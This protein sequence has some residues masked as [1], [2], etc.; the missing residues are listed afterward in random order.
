MPLAC[1]DMISVRR[2][3][4]PRGQPRGDQ[5]ERDGRGVGQHVRGV[6]D[7]R[8]RVRGQAGHDL[9]GHERQDQGERT[10]EPPG[11]RPGNAGRRAVAMPVSSRHHLT[12]SSLPKER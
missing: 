5:D 9:G 7:Q 12:I 11:V 8:Q 4:R 6:G 10:G 3:R 2:S 1:A